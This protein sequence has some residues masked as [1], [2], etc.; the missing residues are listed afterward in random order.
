MVTTAAP[1]AGAVRTPVA[2]PSTL[3]PILFVVVDAEEEFD[4]GA[5]FSRDAVKVEAMRALPPVHHLIR[6]FG[7]RPTYLVDYAVATQHAGYA[8]IREWTA[9]GECSVGA[10]LHPWNTPPFTEPLS[11]RNSFA[12]NLDAA[13]EAAKI[14]A[15]AEAIGDAFGV[16]PRTYK[17]GRYGLGPMTA[18]TLEALGFELDLSVNPGWD[19]SGLGGPSFAGF[20]STPFAFGNRVHMIELPCT[21]GYIGAAGRVGPGLHRA[22]SARVLGPLHAVGLLARLRVVDHLMLSPEGYTLDELRRLTLAL[23]ARGVRTFTLSFHSPSAAPGHTP[24]VRTRRELGTFMATVE[25]YLEFFFGTLGGTTMTPADFRAW[26]V[27]RTG[28]PSWARAAAS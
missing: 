25:A 5:P 6:R 17:A 20:D 28:A 27:A 8:A 16:T 23:L 10:H 18:Q 2:L 26:V 13:L 11:G 4:W 15:V 3:A 9:S 19:Y 22:A 24:Y 1:F 14:R 12:G 7:V 21:S